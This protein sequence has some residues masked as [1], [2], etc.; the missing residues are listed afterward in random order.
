MDIVEIEARS[1]L[2]RS[3]IPGVSH[4]INPYLGCSHGC[5][6]CYAVFMRKYSRTHAHAPWGSFV[7]CKGNVVELL[8]KELARRK[9]PG[10]VMLSSVCDPYQPAEHS[11]Q[12][13]RGCLEVLRHFGWEVEILTRSPLVLRDVDLLKTMP[14]VSVGFSIGTD[15][16]QVRRVL[17][18]GAPPLCLRVEALRELR[19]AGISTWVFI[20]PIL[21]MDPSKLYDMISPSTD[22]VLLDTLNYR[23][24][25][26]EVFM[27]NQWTHALSDEYAVTTR[28]RLIE[29]FGKKARSV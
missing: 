10:S 18:P 15:N 20:A 11:W 21:P 12:L 7:E 26:R 17:E 28:G 16:E 8:R 23:Q 3:K 4:A 5:R 19:S 29:L 27:R 25:V 22:A 9:K 2:V 1:A 13:T 6:Y 14:Q 24:Q